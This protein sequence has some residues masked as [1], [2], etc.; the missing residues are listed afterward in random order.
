[1]VAQELEAWLTAVSR[2]KQ[3]LPA[4]GWHY[5]RAPE[6]ARG[7]DTPAVFSRALA[8][9]PRIVLDAPSAS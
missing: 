4:M 5:C 8:R 9:L 1:M 7:M 3:E 6:V 2:E